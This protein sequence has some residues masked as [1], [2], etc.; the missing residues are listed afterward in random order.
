MTARE[1]K[2]KRRDF[3]RMLS[4][5]EAGHAVAA[6][7]LGIKVADIDMIASEHKDACAFVQTHSA[8]WT[9]GDDP[10]ATARGLYCDLMVLLAGSAAQ[11]RA[12]YP[13]TLTT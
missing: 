3:V 2:M 13:E 1:V 12:G 5:H 8:A 4:Y 11:R 6:R 10:I 9:A 7:K